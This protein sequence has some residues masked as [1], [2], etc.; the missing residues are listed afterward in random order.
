MK[1]AF[2][3][4]FL[5]SFILG[6][7][8]QMEA[9]VPKKKKDTVR[10]LYWNIQNGMWDGQG[11]NYD[12]FVNWINDKDP[13]ICVWCEAEDHK[14]TGTAERIPE[15]QRYFPAGW[16]EMMKR[17]GHSYLFVSGRRDAFP[18]VITSKYPIDTVGQFIGSKPDSV[19]Q[20]GA[21]WARV[22]IEG[23]EFNIVTLHLQP[24]NYYRGIPKEK[25][26]ESQKNHGGEKYRRMETEWILN[27]TT[28]TVADPGKELWMMLG[29]FNSRS[30][31]DNFKYKWSDASEDFLTHNYIEDTAPYYYDVIAE[32]Y[33]GTFVTSTYGQARVDYIYVTKPLLKA[34]TYAE[35][36]RDSY[37]KPVY[38]GVSNFW[39]PS[40]HLPTVVD[41]NLKKI[42]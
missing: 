1:K 31:K 36:I 21:G 42:K 4:V 28:R 18:Q 15:D 17:Y 25:R 41:F 2:A 10:L 27:H 35:T 12:R 22:H 19:V 33:P 23:K 24:F 7:A 8:F 34:I 16:R 20:H 9:K 13:D 11:D 30:R 5:L 40:D 26:E 3:I 29:D 37:T 14:K 6:S 38:S 39:N 32:V